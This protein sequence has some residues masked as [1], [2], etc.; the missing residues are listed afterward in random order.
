MENKGPEMKYSAGAISA[1]V[2]K[3]NG[4]NAKGEPADY[5]TISLQRNYQD[6]DGKWQSTNSLRLNDLPRAVMVLNKAYEYLLLR[7]P[8]SQGP[9]DMIEEE[10]I[11]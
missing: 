10:I 6:K 9:S 5:R 4:T 7:G 1:T 11:R 8:D 3:N 2:W